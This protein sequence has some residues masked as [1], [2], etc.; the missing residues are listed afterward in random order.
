MF[1]FLLVSVRLE[2][3]QQLSVETVSEGSVRVRWRGVSG[4][5]AY[6]LVWGL[7]TGQQEACDVVPC[8]HMLAVHSF[9]FL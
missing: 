7:I 6:S 3:V 4:V 2:A 9:V 5:K 1:M 8:M